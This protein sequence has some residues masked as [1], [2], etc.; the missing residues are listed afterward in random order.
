MRIDHQ[1]RT[2]LAAFASPNGDTVLAGADEESL[3]YPYTY[4][5]TDYPSSLSIAVFGDDK[6]A[7]AYTRQNRTV[8]GSRIAVAWPRTLSWSLGFPDLEVSAQ[9]RGIHPR[10]AFRA[11][12][13]TA[14]WIDP[15]NE[16]LVTATLNESGGCTYPGSSTSCWTRRAKAILAPASGLSLTTARFGLATPSATDQAAVMI[17]QSHIGGSSRPLQ[18]PL[19]FNQLSC[20]NQWSAAGV[21]YSAP[22]IVGDGTAWFAVM[23][24]EQSG[25][26][27]KLIGRKWE[28]TNLSGDVWG[29]E[30][31]LFASNDI[32][33]FDA[34]WSG[35]FVHIAFMQTNVGAQWMEWNG[36]SSGLA[37]TLVDAS[38]TTSASIRIASLGERL[39][40]A[41]P[42]SYY[43]TY[44][45][46]SPSG[47][48]SGV[49]TFSGTPAGASIALAISPDGLK[50]RVAALTG[51]T[52]KTAVCSTSGVCNAASF[53]TTSLGAPAGT[54]GA[55]ISDRFD[56]A[57]GPDSVRVG[58]VGGGT[59]TGYAGKSWLFLHED[60]GSGFGA[61]ATAI[62]TAVVGGVRTNAGHGAG[63]TYNREGEY[64]AA[65]LDL[66]NIAFRTVREFEAVT[67]SPSIVA[68]TAGVSLGDSIR[69]GED[70]SGD[71]FLILGTAW[72]GSGRAGLI[73]EPPAL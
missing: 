2:D 25:V 31:E 11:G 64:R 26:P 32:G 36:V 42:V 33:A 53:V 46:R 47:T 14:T 17:P 3:L 20:G 73:C 62:D 7:I 41:Y 67:A 48:W 43:L 21:T 56:V 35:S 39:S 45:E 13:L 38:A 44:K 1:R 70:R 50:R 68:G 59:G 40:F 37:P 71:G 15:E 29:S 28:T 27:K 72:S 51:S 60:T 58:I 19:R 12:K 55:W 69:L 9:N 30:R 16:Q 4:G 5:L 6:V 61:T 49:T 66:D 24:R 23:T 57:Y 8:D 10:V 52:L 63:L 65:H 18:I 54:G 22:K 34:T